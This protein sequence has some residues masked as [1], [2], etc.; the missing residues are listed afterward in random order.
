[1]DDKD[2]R[3]VNAKPTREWGVRCLCLL[4]YPKY[5]FLSIKFL[6]LPTLSSVSTAVIFLSQYYS[7]ISIL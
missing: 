1:M 3:P 2:A 6:S 4:T 5:F 7:L